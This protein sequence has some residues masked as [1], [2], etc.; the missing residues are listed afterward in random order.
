M[1][2]VY[3]LF[4]VPPYIS[5]RVKLTRAELDVYAQGYMCALG[6]ALKVMKPA[7]KRWEARLMRDYKPR[8]LN[9]TPG[10]S[11]P[12][13]FS[14]ENRARRALVL[15]WGVTVFAAVV[16]VEI[17]LLLAALIFYLLR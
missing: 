1:Q 16:G 14:D 15:F 6:Q 13:V 3:E 11:N 4:T 8:L 9:S 10:P 17:V 2:A 5:S 12:D 7:A